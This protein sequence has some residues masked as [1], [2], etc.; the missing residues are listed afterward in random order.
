MGL[1]LVHQGI[2]Q[3]AVHWGQEGVIGIG[4]HHG[5]IRQRAGIAAQGS[6]VALAHGVGIRLGDGGLGKG[7]TRKGNHDGAGKGDRRGHDSGRTRDL[8]GGI[9]LKFR[10]GSGLF[11][12]GLAVAMAQGLHHADGE[13]D[14]RDG[15]QHLIGL[16]GL[17]LHRAI[18]PRNAKGG[19]VPPSV[20]AG[21]GYSQQE[22]HRGDGEGASARRAQRELGEHHGTEGGDDTGH[23][24]VDAKVVGPL[25]RGE[26]EEEHGQRHD[27]EQALGRAD[28]STNDATVLDKGRHNKHQAEEHGEDREAAG[29]RTIHG[30]LEEGGV[31]RVLRVPRQ[32][33]ADLGAHAGGLQHGRERLVTKGGDHD[34]GASAQ[35]RRNERK[36]AEG[37]TAHGRH[38]LGHGAEEV[39][40]ADE[41][42]AHGKKAGRAGGQCDGCR[43]GAHG[44]RKQAAGGNGTLERGPGKHHAERHDGLWAG[45]V[46][47]RQPEGQE[48]QCCGPVGDPTA[49]DK[50][51]KARQHLAGKDKPD[52]EPGNQARQAH[53]DRGGRNL[54][55]YGNQVVIGGAKGRLRHAVPAVV[56][57][58]VGRVIEDAA[59]GEDEAIIRG[60][61]AE[62]V[63]ES[64]NCGHHAI[65]RTHLLP[66]LRHETEAAS[67]K[68]VDAP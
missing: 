51:A 36:P 54:G 23:A 2:A 4:L 38:A 13:D 14:K 47:I 57:G 18:P 42:D 40:Q 12:L 8:G 44:R 15:E 11:R 45:A 10:Q 3:V 27:D 60:I 26:H 19:Y 33:W 52:D 48:H 29:Q 46:V 56:V 1:V 62:D 21:E 17:E 43:D 25:G 41:E 68:A 31:A 16:D 58:H 49:V 7:S 20:P 34:G 66:R 61:G 6:Q 67:I 32:G 64:Q 24:G 65:E 53:E 5:L 50:L 9:L 28:G 59:H 37:A 22:D 55:E 39:R 63:P 35:E 30:F